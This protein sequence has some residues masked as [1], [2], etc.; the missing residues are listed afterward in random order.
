MVEHEVTRLL[1]SLV[2][3]DSTTGSPGE[4]TVLDSVAEWFSNH[5]GTR[6]VRTGGAHD[7]LLALP[8]IAGERPCPHLV[9]AC[10]ADVVPVGDPDAW[11]SPPFVPTVDGDRLRGRGSSDMKAGLAAAMVAVA[12]LHEAHVPAVLAL[13]V[14]EE[15]GSLGAPDVVDALSDAG[16]EVGAVVI[17]ESTEN[18]V[19]LGHRGA[20]WLRVETRG[21]AAH[22]STP[23]AGRNAVLA[24]ADVLTRIDEVPLGEHPSLGAETVNVGTIAGGSVPNIV[25]DSCVARVDHRVADPVSSE[26]I[27]SWW[28]SQPDVADVRVE[29]DLA[30]VW[31]REDH[32]WVSS[33]PSAVSTAPASY[34]TDASVFVRSMPDVPIVVWGPGDPRTVHTVDESVSLALLAEAAELFLSAG[35]RWS[36]N[37]DEGPSG[38]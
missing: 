24:L 27:R 22:G 7:A 26:R 20:L 8:R 19:V 3:I 13:S 2:R 29:L 34:F 14:G 4:S 36:P 12:E 9:F 10:H 1:S 38:Q 15:L 16:I 6:I 32:P 18:R 11:T 23:S 31:T 5:P 17:P 35:L 37:A 28:R 25:P 21:L 33:L 30:P